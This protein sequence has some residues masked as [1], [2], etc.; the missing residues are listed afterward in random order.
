MPRSIPATRTTK[1]LKCPS[2]LLGSIDTFDGLCASIR[3]P[4]PSPACAAVASRFTCSSSELRETLSFSGSIRPVGGPPEADGVTGSSAVWAASSLASLAV[5]EDAGYEGGKA[6]SE[7][8][9]PPGRPSCCRAQSS[10]VMGCSPRKFASA[11]V[12]GGG[13]YRRILR[14]R[15]GTV[16][17]LVNTQASERTR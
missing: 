6:T 16:Q 1:C 10:R 8:G 4:R 5:G 14:P 7:I 13:R 11:R 2:G 3:E 15:S 17:S 12:W 9:K